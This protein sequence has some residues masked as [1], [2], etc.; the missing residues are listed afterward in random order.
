MLVVDVVAVA[1]DVLVMFVVIVAG[2][3]LASCVIVVV[4]SLPFFLI[5]LS[6]SRTPLGPWAWA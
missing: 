4:Y 5:I 3:V 2:V 1:C 6:A